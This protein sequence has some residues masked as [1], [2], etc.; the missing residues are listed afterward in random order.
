MDVTALMSCLVS[1]NC[2]AADELICSRNRTGCDSAFH[3]AFCNFIVKYCDFY[4]LT[5]ETES[6]KMCIRG[7][8]VNSLIKCLQVS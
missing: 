1:T 7:E 5:F 2:S 4:S 8:E 6:G 3:S